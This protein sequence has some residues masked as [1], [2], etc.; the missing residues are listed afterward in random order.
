MKQILILIIFAWSGWITAQNVDDLFVA[1]AKNRP[2]IRAIYHEFEA[3]VERVAAVSGFPDPNLSMGYFLSPIETRVGPQRFRAS[4]S[5]R[6]PW[7]G[8]LRTVENVQKAKAEVAYQRYLWALHQ[9]YIEVVE[10]YSRYYEWQKIYSNTLAEQELRSQSLDLKRQQYIE[11][12]AS[13]TDITRAEMALDD[14]NR[15]TEKMKDQFDAVVLQIQTVV[16]DRIDLSLPQN[17]SLLDSLSVPTAQAKNAYTEVF[18]KQNEAISERVARTKKRRIPQL[19]LGIDYMAIE[20][21]NL[22]TPEAGKDALMP[23]V[24]ISLPI[25]TRDIA[26]ELNA[27]EKENQAILLHKSEAVAQSDLEI[28]ETVT[29]YNNTMKDITFYSLQLD[30]IDLLL[31]LVTNEYRVGEATYFEII[32]LQQQRLSYSNALAKAEAEAFRL[33]ARYLVYTGKLQ[34]ERIVDE[35]PK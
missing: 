7:W 3:E 10:S 19:N 32:D 5:Q 31:E 26:A 11:G 6:I 28:L 17:L 23:M 8:E 13:L 20:N 15:L 1:A 33:Y 27:L 4:L 34:T 18:Q 25:F 21:T 16:G 30:K 24:G 9:L 22:P 12:K 2:E 14:V 29:N 35:L